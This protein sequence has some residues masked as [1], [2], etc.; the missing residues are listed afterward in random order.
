MMQAV[1]QLQVVQEGSGALIKVFLGRP[2]HHGRE[3]DVLE[4]GELG[5]QMVTLED[6]A[7]VLVSDARLI[8]SAKVVNV[9]PF[10]QHFTGFGPFQSGQCIKQRGLA[11]AACANE[12]GNLGRGDV[13]GDA[14]QHL[15]PAPADR[16]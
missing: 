10:E 11:R 3:A 12:E 7:H 9:A 2:T 13:D 4:R 15:D 8:P 6:K 5:Q 14:A 16:E 1:A